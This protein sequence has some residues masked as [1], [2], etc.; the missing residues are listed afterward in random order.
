MSTPTPK[1][2]PKRRG[3]Q[4]RH[5]S[6]CA[7]DLNISLPHLYLVVNG[8]RTSHRLLARYNA[9]LKKEALS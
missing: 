7:K 5:L 6:R 4:G 1:V 8:Q 9:W 3:P 2:N